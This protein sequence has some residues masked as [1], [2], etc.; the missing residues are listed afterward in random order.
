MSQPQVSIVL[1]TYNGS[2]FLR[3]SIQS[4]LDQTFPDFE[5]II[6]DDCSTDPTPDI[7]REAAAGDPRIR[8]IRHEQN[9]K[10]PGGLN[11]GFAAARGSY[12]TWTSDDN[13]FRP[14]FL[15]TMVAA[16]RARPDVGLVYSGLM[17]MQE[18]GR[19]TK[20][21]DP[22]PPDHN[23]LRDVVLASFLYRRE[24]RDAIGDYDAATFLCEDYDYW[25]RLQARF[26]IAPVPED[27]YLYREHGGSLTAQQSR[28]R[29]EALLKVL[30]KVE[31]LFEPHPRRDYLWTQ[32]GHVSRMLGQRDQ[33]RAYYAKVRRENFQTYLRRVVIGPLAW[34]VKKRWLEWV[35]RPAQA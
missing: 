29:V 27:L 22:E 1:P 31:P 17:V 13:L 6:V 9:R 19:P 18:D 7:A 12:F 30:L 10:L 35:N 8:Y 16:L 2:R 11:T 5:L 28:R 24:V 3:E 23:L 34:P 15:E 33:A 25:L 26:P 4:C 21:V 32:I 20:R 14:R